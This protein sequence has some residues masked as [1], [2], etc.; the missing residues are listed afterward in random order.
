M[1][2]VNVQIPKLLVK[3]C[4][5]NKQRLVH[6]STLNVVQQIDDAYTISKRQGELELLQWT[7]C[8][9]EWNDLKIVRVSLLV[10]PSGDWILKYA[11]FCRYLPILVIPRFTALYAPLNVKEAASY[12]VDAAASTRYDAASFTFNGAYNAVNLGI[13]K[14]GKY[15]QNGAYLRIQSPLGSTNSETRTIFK[16]FHSLLH[17]VH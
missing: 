4:S 17:F 9:K 11:P 15:L 1:H 7:K 13:T 6:V 5:E 16:S 12:L 3:H 2:L 8:N 10:D 14:I